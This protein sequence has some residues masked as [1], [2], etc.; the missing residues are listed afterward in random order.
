MVHLDHKFPPYSLILLQLWP[1]AFLAT[2]YLV[3]VHSITS[4]LITIGDMLLNHYSQTPAIFHFT[5]FLLVLVSCSRDQGAN[6]RLRLV[7]HDASHLNSLCQTQVNKKT[8]SLFINYEVK[9][10]RNVLQ[11]LPP[12][13][14][15]ANI[16]F[17]ILHV[18]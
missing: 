8:Y 16:L 12:H 17:K 13:F 15:C 10:R 4:S 6:R 3:S 9:V 11:M 5:S 14:N 18:K 1:S 7:G 2:I